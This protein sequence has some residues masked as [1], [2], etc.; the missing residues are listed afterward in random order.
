[1]VPNFLRWNVHIKHKI[2]SF[3]MRWFLKESIHFYEFQNSPETTGQYLSHCEL[4]S[5]WNIVFL[6]AC[7][8][9]VLVPSIARA[10]PRMVKG[11][12]HDAVTAEP[13]GY[14]IVILKDR[15]TGTV[16]NQ[17]GE[18][19]IP[20]TQA[21]EELLITC[22]G[23]KSRQ[24][25]VSP[26]DTMLTIALTPTSYLLQEV[27]I[28][29]HSSLLDESSVNQM[30]G[31][32]VAQMTGLTRDVYRA[33]QTLPGVSSNNEVN[34]RF[35]VRGGTSDENL[36]M[37][38]GIRV[39]EP[40]HLKEVPQVSIGIFNVD[41]VQKIDFMNGGF[42]AEHGDALSSV[43]NIEYRKGNA[44]RLAGSAYSSFIDAGFTLEGSLSPKCLWIIGVRKSYLD[45]MMRLMNANPG[46]S[47][48]YDDAQGQISFDLSPMNTIS[49]EFILS[50]DYFT[51]DPLLRRSENWD[52]MLVGSRWLDVTRYQ[53]NNI[54][55]DYR[56][57]NQFANIRWSNVISP[58]L[59]LESAI[60][61]ANEQNNESQ[62]GFLE[63]QSVFHT[64][65]TYLFTQTQ[66]G[67]FLNNLNVK[68]IEV[69][70]SLSYQLT[71]LHTLKVGGSYQRV[72]Y[73]TDRMI[74][75]TD[76]RKTNLT[77]NY[78]DTTIIVYPPDPQYNDTTNLSIDSYKCNAYVQ[79]QWQATE[80]LVFNIGGRFDYFDMN[81]ELSFS[82]RLSAS[83]SFLPQ[84]CLRAAWGIYYQT[85]TYSQL[86]LNTASSNNTVS[87]R[88]LH[89]IVGLEHHPSENSQVRIETYYKEYTD[90]IPVQR[91]SDG[92]LNYGSRDNNTEGYAYGLDIYG[93]MNLSSLYASFSY[94]LMTAKERLKG[95]GA[96][97]HPRY[98]DQL[99]TI[100]S[101]L[102]T[103]LGSRWLG[104]VRCFYGSGFAFTPMKIIHN[105]N[106]E[107][108]QWVPDNK[109]SEHYPPY[110]RIDVRL[111]KQ[112]TLL[113]CPLSMYLDIINIL[114]RKNVFTYRYTYSSSGDPTREPIT[115]FPLIPSI[116]AKYRF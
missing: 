7:L 35:N 104:S 34:A 78:P 8:I 50:N 24:V 112:F 64:E 65:P 6:M 58:I 76:V 69:Q 75:L 21:D 30:K 44:E 111:E 45:F 79:D 41:M 16:T 27:N 29:A 107:I 105:Q 20:C 17:Q 72:S 84:W 60:S 103:Q 109:N 101:V 46:V 77:M 113:D 10:Q 94:S 80:E 5:I 3:S 71:T 110:F 38:D 82:P 57:R 68:T 49:L 2:Y 61:Y 106:L 43:L 48:A 1:M 116:G 19:F 15:M 74:Y 81:K 63:N 96:E 89:Y 53:Q 99:H 40:F 39:Y 4:P 33:V 32:H 59:L 92:S 22:L 97:Y 91:Y 13:L 73:S 86:K 18:F 23:Y 83:Y 42:G 70:L 54:F 100:S 12:I 67:A 36:V 14:A 25:A 102:S 88:A 26:I 85:P 11:V 108:Q 115:L 51:K 37:V 114:G 62:S 98:T 47:I 66:S 95:S 31:D 52:K 56:Y 90:L 87:Q 93:S 9:I 55:A 28:F